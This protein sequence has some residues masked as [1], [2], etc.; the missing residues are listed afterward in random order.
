MTAISDPDSAASAP[1][2]S[3]AR[4]LLVPVLIAAAVVAVVAFGLH[5]LFVGR[6]METTN[7]AY[8]KADAMVVA[9]RVGG[10]VAEVLV[11]AN[12]EVAPGQLLVRIEDDTYKAEAARAQADVDAA[13]ADIRRLEAEVAHQQSILEQMR[14]AAAVATAKAAYAGREADRY[15]KLS[16]TGAVSHQQVDQTRTMSGQTSAELDE[17]QA[18]VTSADRA[19]DVLKAQVGQAESRREAASAALQSAKLDLAATELRSR[20]K[21]RVGDK[22]VSIGQYV[23]AGTRLMSVM[24]IQD[25]YLEAN[26][27]ETQIGRLKVGQ[28]VDIQV[29]ALPGVVVPGR[30]ESWSPG[31]GAEF[32]LLPP[33]NATGNFTK[34]VQRVPVRIRIEGDPSVKAALLPGLSVTATVDTRGR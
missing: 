16:E 34:I 21:G 4:R 29:D 24:P 5:W 9:P 12:Q 2:K 17:A 25:V 30:V 20:I 26:Y 1:A 6:F 15:G 8:L 18:A 22:T 13:E 31:T 23:T 11:G 27:K 32:A 10:Y 33:E 3:G 19:V 28:P 7:D 14:A